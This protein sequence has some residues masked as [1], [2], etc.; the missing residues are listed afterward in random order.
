MEAKKLIELRKEAEKAVAEM[1]DGDLKL[2]KCKEMGSSLLLAFR[3]DLDLPSAACRFPS[4]FLYSLITN[5]TTR[6]R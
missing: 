2:K 4:L 1:P 5:R 6:P 3:H